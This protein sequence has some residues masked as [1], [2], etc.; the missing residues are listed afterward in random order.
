MPAK[1]TVYK[2]RK[3]QYRFNLKA[4]NGD[5]IASGETYPDKKSA[6]KGIASI[7]KAAAAA[8]IIDDTGEAEA[9]ARR[10]RKPAADT[11]AQTAPKPRGRKPAAD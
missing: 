4:T 1:F 3:K 8:K 10:G 6:L 11:T 5:I 7:Q 2:D 9:P